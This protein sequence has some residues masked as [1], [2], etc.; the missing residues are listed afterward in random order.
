MRYKKN[1]L[2]GTKNK[3]PVIMLVNAVPPPERDQ[4]LPQSPMT[5]APSADTTEMWSETYRVTALVVAYA[6]QEKSTMMGSCTLPTRCR[7]AS[8]EQKA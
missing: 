3:T 8:E 2:T 4:I 7:F 6:A 5:S 1:G